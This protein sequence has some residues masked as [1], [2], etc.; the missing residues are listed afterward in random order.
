[1]M[2]DKPRLRGKLYNVKTR[3]VA[4][5]TEGL[6]QLRKRT[7]RRFGALI[8]YLLLASALGLLVDV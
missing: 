4:R 5:D 7:V 6:I 8:S 1:M 3:G 2:G